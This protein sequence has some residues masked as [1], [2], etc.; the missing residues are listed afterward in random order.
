MTNNIAAATSQIAL[1]KQ[2][3]NTL[4]MSI[5]SFKAW[6]VHAREDNDGH[7]VKMLNEAIKKATKKI[8]QYVIVQ[9]AA[10]KHLAQMI[11]YIQ[12]QA[13]FNLKHGGDI[14]VHRANLIKGMYES[15]F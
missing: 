11:V 9:K 12:F 3:I 1:N 15:S 10:K 6:R 4:H 7:Y 5:V 13:P 8:A 14:V 2:T